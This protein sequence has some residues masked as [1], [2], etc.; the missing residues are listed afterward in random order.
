MPL[1][2]LSPAELLMGRKLRTTLPQ[3]FKV[4]VPKWDY[5]Q[6]SQR[7]KRKQAENYHQAHAERQRPDF[8]IGQQVWISDTR[9][10]S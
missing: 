5:I 3:H 2:G 9:N 6:Q 7:Y 10:I 4:L 8:E 1:C